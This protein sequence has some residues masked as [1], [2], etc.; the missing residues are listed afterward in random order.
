MTPESTS[1]SMSVD[2]AEG[3]PIVVSV[4]GALAIPGNTR[5]LADCLAG[6]VLADLPMVVDL[7]G[8]VEIGDAA[9]QYIVDASHQLLCRGFRLT[10]VAPASADDRNI[11][12]LRERVHVQRGSDAMS[13]PM[14][15]VSR[16]R[17]PAVDALQGTYL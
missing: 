15:A 16:R 2:R 17:T 8:V 1:F 3:G 7:V 12:R 9:T 5:L 11:R 13:D 6:A 10:V 14:S 4:Q